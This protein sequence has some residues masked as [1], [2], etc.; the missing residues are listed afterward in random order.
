[1][2]LRLSHLGR[3]E[4]EHPGHHNDQYDG[5]Q[6]WDQF[7]KIFEVHWNSPMVPLVEIRSNTILSQK[8]GLFNDVLP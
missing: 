4:A 8:K 5:K 6:A 3:K 2:L 7:L 1:L